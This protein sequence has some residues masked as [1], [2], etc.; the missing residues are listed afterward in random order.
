[1]KVLVIAYYHPPIN[2]GGT[3]QGPIKFAKHLRRLGHRVTVLTHSYG[4]RAAPEPNVLRVPDPSHNC[5]RRGAR[6]V[7]WS[8]LRLATEALNLVGVPASIYGIWRRRALA[9]PERIRA[10]A[11]PDIILTT[12]PPLEDL[13]IGLGLSR[14]LG[15]PLVAD[16]RDGIMFE[17]VERTRMARH[18]C[19]RR[20]YRTIEGAVAKHA[21]A[22]V[23]AFP[24]LTRYLEVEYGVQTAV[25]IPNG[26]DPDDLSDTDPSWSF[27]P[28]SFNIVHTG[29]FGGSDSDRDVG[30]LCTAFENVALREPALG[31]RLRLH[32]VGPLEPQERR[33]FA[34][35][36]ES[37]V[38]VYHGLCPLPVA[39]SSQLA[40]DALLLLTSM[41]RA[42]HAPGKLYE[43]LYAGR[44]IVALSPRGSYCE[45]ILM[46][47]GSGL[48][49]DPRDSTVIA[50]LLRRL[51][52]EPGAIGALRRDEAAIAAFN[53]ERQVLELDRVLRTA[54]G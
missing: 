21:S 45:S 33:R 28:D 12:Y 47:T 38:V 50:D 9:S 23:T 4:R 34:R 46:D 24:S 10:E 49:V 27:D 54:A 22:T 20:H 19:V 8:L 30:P 39:L 15:V 32:L 11:E 40:A 29:R 2:S 18:R 6:F 14:A 7:Q 51:V 37:G 5:N 31:D 25:T 52:A 44:P 1:V 53:R 48:S 3:H 41:E 43:Y 35:L 36:I 42:G 16:Y 17:P 26:Y 13:E